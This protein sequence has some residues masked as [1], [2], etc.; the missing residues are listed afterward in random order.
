MGFPSSPSSKGRRWGSTP[1]LRFSLYYS[2]EWNYE[3]VHLMRNTLVHPS[4]I[5]CLG[6]CFPQRENN[7][8]GI[9]PHLLPLREGGEGISISIFLFHINT[10]WSG[11]I[12]TQY[13]R[14]GND[15]F[16]FFLQLFWY[17]LRS[18]IA[19]CFCFFF[20]CVFSFLC[21]QFTRKQIFFCWWNIDA[22]TIDW[23]IHE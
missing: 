4:F 15:H 20:L 18:G 21:R 10:E 3:M 16:Y 5:S 23:C 1:Y 8:R 7:D 2:H 14:G 17:V 11:W 13:N 19:L 12:K 22:L 9:F 6:C